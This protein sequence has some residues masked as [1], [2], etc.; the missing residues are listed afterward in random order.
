MTIELIIFTLLVLFTGITGTVLYIYSDNKR[1][2][3]D[4]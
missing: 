2:K 3:K 1:R 4:E